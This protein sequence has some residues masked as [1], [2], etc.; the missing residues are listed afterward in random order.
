MTDLKKKILDDLEMSGFITELEISSILVKNGWHVRSNSNYEDLDKQ[1]SREIDI[2]AVHMP[3]ARNE[4]ISLELHLVIE[5]KK[6]TKKPWVIFTSQKT[7]SATP[8][9][10]MHNVIRNH[11]LYD[12][13]EPS[14]ST[15]LNSNHLSLNHPR[16]KFQRIGR[17]Y[18]EAFKKPEEPSKI[19]EAVISAC[20][21]CKYYQTTYDPGEE[22]TNLKFNRNE[23]VE[24]YLF[25]PIVVL[26]GELYEVYLKNNGET[27]IE[28]AKDWLTL[29]VNYASP[30]YGAN[31]FERNIDFFV[32]IVK[33]DYFVHYQ[34]TLK[35]WIKEVFDNFKRDI[36]A[37]KTV[38]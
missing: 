26:E 23:S 6:A 29:D 8:G 38:A 34:E 32:D 9:W 4:H 16:R 33:K 30:N 5:I 19:F 28:E 17:N 3:S 18:H 20:K 31:P 1:S 11:R 21:A 13:V 10:R 24:C 36:K 7:G 22:I 25:L 14:G 15:I 2:V 35:D 12:M 37:K 27:A